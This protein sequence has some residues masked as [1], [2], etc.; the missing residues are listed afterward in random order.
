MII[1]EE[2]VR[3]KIPDIMIKKDSIPEFRILDDYEYL[4]ELKKKILEELLDFLQDDYV[5][6][7]VD[8]YDLIFAIL[9]AKGIDYNEFYNY[10]AYNEQEKGAY[11]KKIYLISDNKEYK[12]HQF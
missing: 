9:D 1:Y 8:V 12:K 11:K 7:L 3:D 2:L 4:E 5:D 6:K 10:R